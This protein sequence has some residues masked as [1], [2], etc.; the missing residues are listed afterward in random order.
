VMNILL[1]YTSWFAALKGSHVLYTVL[2]QTI[3]TAVMIL[4]ISPSYCILLPPLTHSAGFP[5]NRTEPWSSDTELEK[6][7]LGVVTLNWRSRA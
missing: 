1:K 7:S 4:M 6:Q 2:L 3:A 5:R